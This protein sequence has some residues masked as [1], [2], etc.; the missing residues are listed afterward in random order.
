MLFSHRDAGRSREIDKII[1][2]PLGDFR[3]RMESDV[4]QLLYRANGATTY[5]LVALE[6][7]PTR[8]RFLPGEQVTVDEHISAQAPQTIARLKMRSQQRPLEEVLTSAL[9]I[10][11]SH[12]TG[13]VWLIMG[14]LRRSGTVT[15]RAITPSLLRMAAEL[16]DAYETGV[17][18]N[19]R[20]IERLFQQSIERLIEAQGTF[21]TQNLLQAVASTARWFLNSASAYVALPAAEADK[22]VF[23]A[24]DNT[25]T[26][27]FAAL[28]LGTNEGMGGWV[29]REKKSISTANYYSDKRLVG[30]PIDAT[31]KEG[32]KSAVCSP[33]WRDGCVT[34]LLYVA[35]RKYRAFG[36]TEV[37]L[38]EEFAS[39]A[40]EALR[41]DDLRNHHDAQIL[42]GE[43]ERLTALLHDEV[44]SR[45]L[46]MGIHAS[47]S[48]AASQDAKSRNS[49]ASIQKE[50]QDCIDTIRACIK[51]AE[52]DKGSPSIRLRNLAMDLARPSAYSKVPRET[53]FKEAA[54]AETLINCR[55]ASLL[56]TLVDE[57][58]SN[59]DR[60][61]GATKVRITIAT[62]PRT[63]TV[64]VTDNGRGLQPERIPE[65][66]DTPGHLGLKR[67]RKL[68]TDAG[69]RCQFLC[70][71]FGGFEVLLTL[72]LN[73]ESL[74]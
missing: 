46:N 18:K 20:Q 58:T 37:R 10:P 47:L 32:F 62:T 50:A 4:I 36:E 38:L 73:P 15:T 23:A 1:A 25:R 54:A 7:G 40:M 30:A 27:D 12:S 8:S 6:C 60:H 17:A 21:D 48:A 59:A 67:M 26:A 33:L 64:S 53:R 5:D 28:R 14:N 51:D 69:G 35:D 71:A 52:P 2:G 34:G 31:R 45:L 49:L 16:R 63:L 9:T 42:Q 41:L 74:H 70:P 66:L 24:T 22:F 19:S 29:R 55:T 11:W 3:S 65:L 56:H 13:N 68:A 39:R 61:S 43:R 72:P 44:I 57:A